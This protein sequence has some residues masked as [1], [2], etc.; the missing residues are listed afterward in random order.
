MA[1]IF[2]PAFLARVD[3]DAPLVTQRDCYDRTGSPA[4]VNRMMHLD[5]KITLADNDLRKV[6]QACELA[7]V[8]VRYPLLDERLMTFAAG[9]PPQIQLKDNRLRWFFKQALADFLPPAIIAKKKHGFGAAGGSVDG[10]S[11]RRSRP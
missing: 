10:R 8:D 1:E 6:N 5:L 4:I 7:G 2:D 11:T 3:P 9:V